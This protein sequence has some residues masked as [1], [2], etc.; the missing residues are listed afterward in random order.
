MKCPSCRHPAQLNER[1]AADLPTAFHIN[2]LL[3][4]D[5]LLKKTQNNNADPAA[6]SKGDP[7]PNRPSPVPIMCLA[8]NDKRDI[9][10]ETCSELVCFKCSAESHRDHQCDR[11]E[12]LFPRHKKEIEAC[13]LPVR[14]RIDEIEQILAEFTSRE[15]EIREQGEAVQKEIDETYQQMM[16]RLQE[17]REKVSQDVA[18]ALQ[19]KLQL[20]SAQRA[21]VETV[22]VKLKSCL[23]F[24]EEE[25][26]SQAQFQIQ[27]AKNQLVKHLNQAHSEVKVSELQPVQQPNIA[28]T[29]DKSSLSACSKIGDINSK[30][31]FLWPGLFRVD[32]LSR[33]FR[34]KEIELF[35][36]S[37]ISL[38]ASRLCC[39]LTP[40]QGRVSKPVECPVTDVGEGW[41][42]VLILSNTAG[43]HQLRVLIDGVDIYGSPFSVQVVDWN[44]QSL[45]SFAKGLSLPYGV[46]VTD[47]GQHVVVAESGAS[48]V[49]LYS[50]SWMVTKKVFTYNSEPGVVFPADV[51]VSDD[52]H[53]F[54]VDSSGKLGKF[55]FSLAHKASI[56][57]NCYGV[58]IHPLGDK[59]FC[60]DRTEHNVTVLNTDLTH[61]YS[62]GSKELFSNPCGIAI[63]TSGMVYVVDSIKGA[64]F[65]FTP[66][67]EH[68]ATIGSQGEEPHQFGQPNSICIDSNEIVYVTDIGKHQV[69]MFT[70]AGKFL[71]KFGRSG[72][73]LSPR[74]IAVDKAGNVYVCD[75]G[76]DEVLVSKPLSHS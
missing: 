44:R 4:I 13:L 41:F 53:I 26:R 36:T 64:V 70:T 39:Q 55:T 45:M 42:R 32:I 63:D 16:N 34:D 30:Q 28:F 65:K 11:A 52:R 38:S 47:D 58:A 3:E 2:N 68:L 76:N 29:T 31:S 43:L 61:S 17:S 8:H 62:F 33:V 69:M 5:Q 1:G 75:Y 56:H 9:Y 12:R 6:E 40:V 35:R 18:A 51:A 57:I 74:G 71:A 59:V 21:H 49:T 73:Q 23:E 67:G 24:V 37:S 10:C 19:E 20:H 14:K 15:G 46:A 25:L 7:V 27:A 54:V 72:K 50:I 22:L 66:E 60:I 48:R